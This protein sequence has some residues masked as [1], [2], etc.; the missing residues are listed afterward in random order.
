MATPPAWPW[1]R[2]GVEPEDG[3]FLQ[4]LAGS[5]QGAYSY[6]EADLGSYEPSAHWTNLMAKLRFGVPVL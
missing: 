2:S 1:H 5:W 6:S 3:Q 4:H